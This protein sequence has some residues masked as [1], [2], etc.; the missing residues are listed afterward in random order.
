MR[1]T[2]R[3][4]SPELEQAARTMRRQPTRAEEVLWRALQKK[5]VAGLKFRRQHPVGR[6]RPGFLLSV[7]QARG[8]G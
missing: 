8:G 5:Q 1:R 2:I 4:T 6:F 7:A 3:G